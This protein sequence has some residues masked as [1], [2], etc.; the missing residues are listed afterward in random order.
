MDKTWRPDNWEQL[1]QKRKDWIDLNSLEAGAT[2][3]LEAYLTSG[4]FIEDAS[5]YCREAGWE[6]PA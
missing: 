6:E 2:V 1:K 4:Q 5:E 3:M